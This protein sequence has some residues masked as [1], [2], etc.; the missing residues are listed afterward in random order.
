MV[1]R[2]VAVLPCPAVSPG[3]TLDARCYH[4]MPCVGGA[5]PPPPP[6]N[7]PRG[8]DFDW[9]ATVAIKVECFHSLVKLRGGT[10]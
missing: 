10:R 3:A 7:F 1:Q 5:S 8:L 9:T 4:R 6:L 2:V